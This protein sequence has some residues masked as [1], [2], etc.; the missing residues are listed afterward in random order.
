MLA[1]TGANFVTIPS[2]PNFGSK[3]VLDADQLNL[4]E[5]EREIWNGD[6]ATPENGP[7]L[8]GATALSGWRFYWAGVKNSD[9]AIEKQ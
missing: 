8:D 7:P 3:M 5:V 9:I 1:Q 4:L 2:E 6:L